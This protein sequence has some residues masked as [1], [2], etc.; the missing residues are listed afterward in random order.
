MTLR[1]LTNHF[2]PRKK[3]CIDSLRILRILRNT[4]SSTCAEIRRNNMRL[5]VHGRY[6]LYIKKIRLRS[7]NTL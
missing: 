4:F 1:Q 6:C 2:F 3:L 7:K 5:S